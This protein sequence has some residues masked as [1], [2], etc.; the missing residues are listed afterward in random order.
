MGES[1]SEAR[2]KRLKAF[3]VVSV[4]EVVVAQYG[5]CF[6]VTPRSFRVLGLAQQLP[7]TRRR[8][9]NCK[10]PGMAL[11]T[12]HGTTLAIGTRTALAT[13]EGEGTAMAS[14]LAHGIGT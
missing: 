11:S 1:K 2:C 6:L 8:H 4:V 13:G 5:R 12:G 3:D 10:W 9:G 7:H 14:G